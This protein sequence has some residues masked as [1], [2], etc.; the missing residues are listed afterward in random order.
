MAFTGHTYIVTSLDRSAFAHLSIDGY[1]RAMAPDVQLLIAR[2]GAIGVTDATLA[3]TG[4][5]PAGDPAELRETTRFDEHRRVVHARALRDDVHVYGND[6]GLITVSRGLVGRMEMSVEVFDPG[7]GLGRGF[8]RFAQSI[9]G[10]E[11]PLFA[12]VTPGNTRSLRLFLS[13]GFQVVASEVVI[14]PGS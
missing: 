12:A 6:A 2:G 5:S 10:M 7:G 14:S 1:G 3:W 9:V 8:V 13:E 4:R 11:E